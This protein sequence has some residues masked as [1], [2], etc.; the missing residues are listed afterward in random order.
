M[1]YVV[2]SILNYVQKE[3]TN[4]AILLNGEWGSGKTYFWENVLKDKIEN[5][6]L[7]GKKQKTIYVSLYGIT[8]IEE[9]NKRIVLDNILKKSEFNQKVSESKWG[10]KLTE[11]AKM[12]VGVVK[13]FEIPVLT[14]VLDTSVNYENLLDFTDT[15][16][17]FDDL[18]R[19]NLGITDILGYINNFVE[20]DGVKA[21]IISNENEISGKFIGQ[22]MELKM[23]VS[24]IVL[25]KE[26]IFGQGSAIGGKTTVPTNQLISEKLLSLFNKTNEYKRIKEKL[27][28]KTLTFAPEH[29]SLIGEIVN[30]ISNDDLR[31]FLNENLE[32]IIATFQ[33]S[34]TKNIRILK[35][36]IDD[37]EIIYPKFQEKYS[38]QLDKS[39]L[40][41]ILVF[42]L[43]VSFDIKSGIEGNEEFK[44]I[45]SNDEF[46]SNI[47]L[48]RMGE[49]KEKSYLESFKE[50]YYG[51]YSSFNQLVFFKFAELLVRKG[52]FDTEVFEQEMDAIVVKSVD[53]TPAYIKFIR[54]GYW[55][56]SDEEFLETEQNAYQQLVSGEADFIWYF[57]AFSLYRHLSEKGLVSKD[58]QTLKNELMEGLN[59]AADNAEYNESMDFHSRVAE[60]EPED[61]DL[62][63]FNDKII[64]IKN[65]LRD[66][67]QKEQVQILVE[68]MTSNFHKFLVDMR[69]KYFY[70]PVFSY[71]DVDEIFENILLLSNSDTSL[72]IQILE[73]RYEYVEEN[74]NLKLDWVNLQALKIKLNEY[75]N[76]KNTTPKIALL[77]DLVE[78]IERLSEVL[79]RYGSEVDEER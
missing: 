2:D 44:N 37:F 25:E 72:M 74:S 48:A 31:Q 4:Y 11:L 64:E 28:G 22:N 53:R 46:L 39:V 10:G 61:Y 6:E 70:I 63:E 23:L 60:I 69:E 54:N 41:Y 51:T 65:K 33:Q 17:C 3:N 38:S 50:K 16:L 40:S 15:V 20:H 68:D 19:A 49:K 36:A 79:S 45:E 66:E 34:G 42:I 77:K 7:N 1:K 26:G 13:S 67:R 59:I 32:L 76:E 55:E 52:I 9:I 27:I 57:R 14:Q 8:S 78:Y 24:S 71:C 75:I 62:K 30:R 47:A 58:I 5:V 43:A 18:E 35:Q 73:K 21:I 12:T 29:Q 56:L